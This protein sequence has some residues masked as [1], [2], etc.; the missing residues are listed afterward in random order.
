IALAGIALFGIAGLAIDGSAK[1]SD[2]RHAQNA[3]DT[4]ALAAALKMARQPAATCAASV[5]QWKCD[6]LD[7]ALENGYDNDLTS[8]TV[9]VHNPPISGTFSDCSNIHF[10]CYDYVQVI[11][12]SHVDTWFMRVLGFQKTTNVVQAVASKLSSNDVYNI[13]GDAVVALAPDG[14]ALM[15]QGNTTL[16]VIGGGM[17][18]NSDDATCSFK[19]DS[20]AGTTTIDADTSGTQ[21]TI[22]MVG[23]A[24]INTGCPPDAGLNPAGGQQIP[25][26]P[27]YKEIPEPDECS[28]PGGKSNTSSTTTLTPGYFDKIPGTGSSWK[29]TVILTPGVYCVGTVVS[30]NASEILTVSGTYSPTSPGVFIYIKPGG[31]FTFN[32]GSGVNLWGIRQAQVDADSDLEPYKG[33]LFYVAPNY[34]GTPANCKINGHSGDVFVG[35][36]YAP[37]CNITIDGSSGSSGFQSQLIGYNVKFA[38]G[39][40]VTLNYTAGNAGVLEIPLQVGLSR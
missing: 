38:G 35:S 20:C 9:A 24:S 39:S 25:F 18:S 28:T 37:Y 29:N 16:K 5:P 10:D 6:A 34:S 13:G 8:N 1:F 17:Y 32:G 23:G 40:N 27:P 19:K 15:S 7:R 4:A 2:R 22:T 3:A 26:P 21:G 11:I 33:F 12:T 14:C 30:T 31:S 36:I